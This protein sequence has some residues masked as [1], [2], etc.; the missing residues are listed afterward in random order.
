MAE[1]INRISVVCA[2]YGAS[3]FAWALLLLEKGIKR[4]LLLRRE[5]LPKLGLDVPELLSQMRSHWLHQL[6]AALL[7]LFQDKI[8]LMLLLGRELQI[9]LDP[10]EEF[11]PKP[12]G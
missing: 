10:A 12:Y 5:H 7:A 4:L 8:N 1:R 2:E 9:P 11:K 6:S 3:G